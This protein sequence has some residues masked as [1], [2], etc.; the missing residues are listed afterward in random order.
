MEGQA[1]LTESELLLTSDEVMNILLADANLRRRAATCVLPAVR[2]GGG[3]FRFRKS[4]LERWIELQI[5]PARV[6]RTS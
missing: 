5:P 6:S 2:C 1:L 4:D 3:E